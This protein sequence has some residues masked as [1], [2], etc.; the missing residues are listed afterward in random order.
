MH[1]R[2]IFSFNKEFY[3]MVAIL[4]Y[5]MIILLFSDESDGT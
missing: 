5:N 1:A 2:L 3:N 4:V